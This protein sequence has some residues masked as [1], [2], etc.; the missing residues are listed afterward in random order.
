MKPIDDLT[1]ICELLKKL[2]FLQK[3][4]QNLKFVKF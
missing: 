1:F 3:V 2:N 4:N